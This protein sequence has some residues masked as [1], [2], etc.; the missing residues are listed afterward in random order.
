MKWVTVPPR[1]S[2]TSSW[3]SVDNFGS[4]IYHSAHENA[5][6]LVPIQEA[7]YLWVQAEKPG[8]YLAGYPPVSATFPRN[9]GEMCRTGNALEKYTDWFI[10]GLQNGLSINTTSL[11]RDKNPPA[12]EVCKAMTQIAS[13]FMS[14]LKWSRLKGQYLPLPIPIRLYFY[15]LLFTKSGKV[16]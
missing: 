10:W 16:R 5:T 13:T 1:S 4:S 8:R 9:R 12:E 2:H 14:F 3:S 7:L 15:F 11:S 6:K